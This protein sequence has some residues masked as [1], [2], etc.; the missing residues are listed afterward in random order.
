MSPHAS[1]CPGSTRSP[2]GFLGAL[3]AGPQTIGLRPEHIS[4]GDGQAST[5]T[6]VEHLGDQ[7]RLH[8]KLEGHDIVTLTD[9]HT[10]LTPGDTVAIQP[11]NPL[12]FD[13]QGARIA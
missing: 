5:V 6:R 8:L 9:V 3:P 10:A 4:Q 7:T 13:G 2:P 12:W 1:G 11:K